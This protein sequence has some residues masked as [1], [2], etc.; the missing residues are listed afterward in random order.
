M[1][2]ASLALA[3]FVLS[4]A[5]QAGWP[6]WNTAHNPTLTGRVAVTDYLVVGGTDPG[7]DSAPHDSRLSA[8]NAWPGAATNTTG[9]NI[10]LSG[11]MGKTGLT[12]A[13]YTLLADTSL[14]VV[15]DQRLPSITTYTLIEGVHFSAQT[16]D[17]QTAANISAAI[18]AWCPGVTATPSGASVLLSKTANTQTVTLS[19]GYG[20]I[21]GIALGVAGKVYA[22]TDFYAR[23]DSYLSDTTISGS[24]MLPAVDKQV[25]ALSTTLQADSATVYNI[26]GPEIGSITGGVDG[27]LILLRFKD[28]VGGVAT[29]AFTPAPGLSTYDAVDG[30]WLLLYYDSGAASPYWTELARWPNPITPT[31]S[32]GS[33]A[34]S[35]TP[36]KIGDIFV[37]ATNHKMYFAE[38]AT[39]SACWVI[40]N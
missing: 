18:N 36:G 11:G 10:F 7:A 40:A 22:S 19:T 38:C 29:T 39:S 31:I 1:R 24:T 23:A 27:R 20:A 9:G 12:I 34:P 6:A 17:A 13:D 28:A 2:R 16:S 3:L 14:W 37:D 21:Y 15:L 30:G 33:A 35:S 32:S 5:A 4:L 8:Q 25:N 26:T